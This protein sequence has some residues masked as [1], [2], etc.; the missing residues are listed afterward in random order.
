MSNPLLNTGFEVTLAGLIGASTAQ[1]LKL[2]WY[3]AHKKPITFQVLLSTGGM[4]SSHSAAVTGIATSV[5]LVSGWA[6]VDFA[7]ALGL[8]LIVMYDATGVRRAAGRMA[9]VL[10]QLTADIYTQHPDK[11]PE[12]LKELLGH[13]PFEVLVGS[14]VGS[15]VAVVLHRM[16]MGALT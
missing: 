12:R 4:P 14:L 13:T 5:G 6:S 8:S 10:N 2:L 3:V 7:I 11:V 15:G 16:L 1:I 9:G